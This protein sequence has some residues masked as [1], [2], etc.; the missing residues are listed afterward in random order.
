MKSTFFH[1][2]NRYGN[3]CLKPCQTSWP[4]NTEAAGNGKAGGASWKS[5]GWSQGTAMVKQVNQSPR[6]RERGCPGTASEPWPTQVC[7]IPSCGP[8]ALPMFL[9]EAMLLLSKHQGLNTVSSFQPLS[10][11]QAHMAWSRLSFEPGPTHPLKQKQIDWFDIHQWACFLWLAFLRLLSLSSFRN[12]W[13]ITPPFQVSSL[14]LGSMARRTDLRGA[15]TSIWHFPSCS[16]VTWDSVKRDERKKHFRSG[17]KLAT[18]A[19]AQVAA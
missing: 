5:L 10:L 17:L 18:F 4:E 9:W 2:Q 14:V 3:P 8:L 16:G 15:F 6:G 13:V 12:G 1:F 11:S 7:G 19:G